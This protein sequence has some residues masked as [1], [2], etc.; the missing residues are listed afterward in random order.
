MLLAI[1]ILILFYL[2]GEQFI[3]YFNQ[4]SSDF[5]GDPT[6]ETPDDDF[7]KLN[8]LLYLSQRYRKYNEL[9]YCEF[10][11]GVKSFKK[12]I[13]KITI[14]PEF[15]NYYTDR[16]ISLKMEIPNIFHS[17]VHNIPPDEMSRFDNIRSDL[18][19][20]LNNLTN[21]VL[22]KPLTGPCPVDKNLCPHF[23][24]TS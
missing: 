4:I 10:M 13:K 1:I 17:L 2:H 15:R 8:S 16:L 7:Q 9:I 12:I 24:F 23:H 11:T 21:L 5:T 6:E 3:Y 18:E 22:K 19:T 14:R 20:F